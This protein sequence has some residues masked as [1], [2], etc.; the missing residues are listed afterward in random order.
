M[1]REQRR[2]RS[3]PP[4]T[5]DQ[6]AGVAA[7]VERRARSADQLT[8]AA[9]ARSASR[10]EQQAGDQTLARE[11]GQHQPDAVGHDE[12]R[13]RDRAVA[14]LASST[15]RM[16]STSANSC[17]EAGD[18]EQ[19]RARVVAA[20]EAC[21]RPDERSRSTSTSPATRPA[22]AVERARRAH[23]EQ[24]GGDAAGS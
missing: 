18:A 12:Q 7:G 9:P 5:L 19:V 23:L 24:L 20:A 21:Q 11:L 17:D 15:A 8:I 2:P 16:P 14:E 1:A 10:P 6:S 22:D 4:I 3:W 13:R